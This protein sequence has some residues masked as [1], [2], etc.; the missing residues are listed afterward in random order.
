MVLRSVALILTLFIPTL[1]AAGWVKTPGAT[2]PIPCAF[3]SRSPSVC[4]WDSI[5]SETT[6]ALLVSLCENFSVHFHDNVDG[7]TSSTLSGNVAKVWLQ[8][9]SGVYSVNTAVHAEGKTLTGDDAADLFALR[10][11]DG[12]Y[13]SILTTI[14]T[15]T[16]R[17]QVFCYPRPN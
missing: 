4:S 7:D 6:D 12:N 13:V 8:S 11:Q 1:A 17:V 9:T 5:T 16:A 10:R 2:E 3:R 15:G 14:T